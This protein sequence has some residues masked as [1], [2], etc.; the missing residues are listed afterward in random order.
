MS[1]FYLYLLVAAIVFTAC[2]KEKADPGYITTP[3][4]APTLSEVNVSSLNCA[5]ARISSVAT[6][7]ASY[8][9]TVMIPYTGGNG[10]NYSFGYPVESLGVKGLKATLQPGIASDTGSLIYSVS[11]IP[12]SSGTSDFE[13]IFGKQQCKFSIPINHAVNTAPRVSAMGDLF[14]SSPGDSCILSGGGYD[15]ENDRLSF[16]WIKLSGPS[17]AVIENPNSLRTRVSGLQL[18]EYTFELSATDPYGLKGSDTVRVTVFQ[19]GQNEYLFKDLSWEC[20]MGC[21]VTI[22]NLYSYIPAG[23]PFLV[24]LRESS[25]APWQYVKSE[26]QWGPTDKY[27]Y[28]TGNNTLWVYSDDITGK[29]DVKIQY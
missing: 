2:K 29:A 21:S 15:L 19:P 11:G 18:G 27:V 17:G 16:T 28:G 4:V 22:Y 23:K 14:L 10:V 26:S 25:T 7:G 12:L 13:I 1:K 8:S 6:A 9:A 24:F 3:P 20:P 5:A